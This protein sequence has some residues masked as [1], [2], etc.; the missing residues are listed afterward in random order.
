[1][2]LRF[3]KNRPL[4]STNAALLSM[5]LLACL[6]GKVPGLFLCP[7]RRGGGN[8]MAAVDRE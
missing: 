2:L 3:K 7:G 4:A 8:G 1:M 6:T 5:T